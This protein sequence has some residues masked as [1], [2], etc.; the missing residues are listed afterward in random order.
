MGPGGRFDQCVHR[1]GVQGLA[2]RL[3][4]DRPVG[5]LVRRLAQAVCEQA[6]GESSCFCS[7]SLEVR[8]IVGVETR[9]AAQT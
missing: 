9:R 4:G 2:Q 3:G 8:P 6:G 7:K 5:R 1:L